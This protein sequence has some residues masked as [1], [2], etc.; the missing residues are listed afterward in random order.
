MNRKRV[1]M[2]AIVAAAVIAAGG[3]A[4]Y[5]SLNSTALVK[6]TT[7]GLGRLAVTVDAPGTVAAANQRGVY[8]PTA[9]TIAKVEVADGD[10]VSA[11]QVL[12]RLNTAP[13]KLALAQAEAALATA[14]AQANSIATASPTGSEYAAANRAISAARSA[15]GTAKRNYADYLAE[16]NAASPVEQDAMRPTLRTLGSARDQASATLALAKANRDRLSRSG[17]NGLAKDAGSLSVAAAKLAVAQAKADLGGAVLTA[18]VGG[19]VSVPSGVES[20]A[21]VSPG[22]AVVSVDEP[23]SLVFEASVDQADIASVAPGQPATVTLDAFAGQTLVGKVLSRSQSAS[24]TATGGV[25]FVTKVSLAAGS[26][27]PLAGMGGSV[28]I[29]VKELPDAITVPAAAVVSNGEQRFVF[30]LADGRVH[31]TVV[32]IGA[33]TDTA[34][35]ITDGVTAGAQVVVTGASSLSDGQSVRVSR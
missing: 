28:S 15:L 25:A 35:Q 10:R 16:F 27:Q 7:A 26:V 3:G 34:I 6:V 8:P 33:E 31:R 29:T 21:G 2:I 1:V 11:G 5:A 22:M 9:A 20:G 32:R 18:P 19:T 12:V 23:R 17:Q 14:R 24:T 4:A 13:L 30:V